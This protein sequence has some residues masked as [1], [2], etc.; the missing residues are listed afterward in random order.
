LRADAALI[1]CN[2]GRFMSF[3]S[4]DGRDPR[5]EAEKARADLK[6][7]S[8]MGIAIPES[9]DEFIPS[10]TPETFGEHGEFGN[11]TPP[12]DREN[13]DDPLPGAP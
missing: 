9:D 6:R 1:P 4:N 10:V 3:N 12:V 2:E 8:E 11:E 5:S 13:R 7:N